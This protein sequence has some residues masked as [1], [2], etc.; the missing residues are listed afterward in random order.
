MR[1]LDS[2]SSVPH[3]ELVMTPRFSVVIPAHNGAR[4]LPQLLDSVEE[5]KAR[6]VGAEPIEVVVVDNRSTDATAEIAQARG[7]R[8]VREE[9]RVI[10]AVRNHVFDPL[11]EAVRTADDVIYDLDVDNPPRP[12]VDPVVEAVAINRVECAGS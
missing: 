12:V 2:L 8:L 6:Y 5:A 10:A 9:K 7:C 3:I 11:G 1:W 4:F